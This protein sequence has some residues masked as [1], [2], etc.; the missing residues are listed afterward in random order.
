[1]KGLAAG[2]YDDRPPLFSPDAL[3]RLF[4]GTLGGGSNRE[5]AGPV[6]CEPPA[7]T[8]SRLALLGWPVA[9]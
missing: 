7:G 1:M 4:A 3:G 2:L 6:T 5:R 8:P 9:A